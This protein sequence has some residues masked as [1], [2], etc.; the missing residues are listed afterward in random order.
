LG[1][2]APADGDNVLSSVISKLLF[3]GHR[4]RATVELPW[5]DDIVL[6]LAPDDSWREGQPVA[7]RL[8][9][10]ALRAWPTIV[11][12][13]VNE[14]QADVPALDEA[15]QAHNRRATPYPLR[16]PGGRALPTAL[17]RTHSP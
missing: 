4:Y 9:P 8:S 14:L 3:A 13:D 11:P 2:A 1:V 7:V 5:G 10:D 16:Y 17:K 15:A 6:S 12:T